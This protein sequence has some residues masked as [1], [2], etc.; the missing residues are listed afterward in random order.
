LRL[1]L[2]QATFYYEQMNSVEFAI[3]FTVSALMQ[4]NNS[5]AAFTRNPRVTKKDIELSTTALQVLE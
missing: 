5:M 2:S 4:A 1:A 3:K